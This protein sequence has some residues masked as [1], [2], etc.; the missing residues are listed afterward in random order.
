MAKLRSLSSKK[1]EESM[2]F[3]VA[4]NVKSLICTAVV[5]V[6]EWWHFR[7]SA[8]IA[9]WKERALKNKHPKP[10]QSIIYMLNINLSLGDGTTFSGVFGWI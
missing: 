5:V 4:G 3:L 2:H 6:V 1:K 7:E 9:E 10:T 8:I